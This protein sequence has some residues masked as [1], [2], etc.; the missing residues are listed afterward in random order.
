[1]VGSPTTAAAGLE[2]ADDFVL[3]R[4]DSVG[5]FLLLLGL[6]V[7][8]PFVFLSVFL[9]AAVVFAVVFLVVRVLVRLLVKVDLFSGFTTVKARNSDSAL[10]LLVVVVLFFDLVVV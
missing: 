10:L 9:E 4:T 1:L 7:V 6:V 2:E 8:V 3:L 5:G